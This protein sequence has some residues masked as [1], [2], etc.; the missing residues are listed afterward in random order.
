M[1]FIY[2]HWLFSLPGF[3]GYAAICL[4]R[5]ILFRD[6]KD[7]VSR[8]LMAHEMKHQEQMDRHGVAGFYVRYL[9]EYLKGLARFRS[10]GLAYW[11]NKFE[12]EAR[13]AS[14]LSRG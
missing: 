6:A 7:Q 12:V 13:G 8:E 1:E 5:T 2:S 14:I 9:W 3:S 10:H 11:W 4:G